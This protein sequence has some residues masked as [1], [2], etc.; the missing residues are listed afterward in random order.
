VQ[1]ECFN[2]VRDTTFTVQGAKSIGK[3]DRIPSQVKV[4]STIA[5][6]TRV[7]HHQLISDGLVSS[8]WTSPWSFH[9]NPV[10]ESR[11]V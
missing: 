7:Q 6:L 8:L 2:L 5:S 11:R 3:Q 10:Q 9:N 1:L 4:K